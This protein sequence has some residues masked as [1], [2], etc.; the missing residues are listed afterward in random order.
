M[1]KP[2]V[3]VVAD[4]V[5][6]RGPKGRCRYNEEAKRQLVWLCTRPGA[7][8]ARLAMTHGVN[9]NQLRGWMQKYAEASDAFAGVKR[10]ERTVP[11]LLPVA[12]IPAGAKVPTQFSA[13]GCIEIVWATA[14][15]RVRGAVDSRS[16]STV[17]DCL[18]HRA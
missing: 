16:L 10:S 4:L 7:S 12:T 8:V 13:D 18:A 5:M 1:E 11:L 14:T 6:S 9:A 3:E 15:V 2:N 17:L